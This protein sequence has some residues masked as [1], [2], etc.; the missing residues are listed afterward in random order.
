MGNILIV[1]DNTT[2]RGSLREILS[3]RFPFM[4]IREAVDSKEALQKIEDLPP[5]LIFMDIRLPGMNGLELTK[6]IKKIYNNIVVAVLTS[7]D[8]QEYRDAAYQCGAN[9]FFTKG[10]TPSDEIMT[11]VE[12]VVSERGLGVSVKPGSNGSVY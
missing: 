11:F 10:S 2:F 8:L 7:Y 1:E 9:C 6:T 5:D 4:G 12:S 3:T